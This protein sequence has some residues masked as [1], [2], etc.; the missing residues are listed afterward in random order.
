MPTRAVGVQSASYRQTRAE[1]VT[2]AKRE[3]DVAERANERRLRRLVGGLFVRSFATIEEAEHQHVLASLIDKAVTHV[4]QA[5]HH[6][7]YAVRAAQGDQ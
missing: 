6:Q 2:A 5:A 7:F 1:L 4:E 3:R